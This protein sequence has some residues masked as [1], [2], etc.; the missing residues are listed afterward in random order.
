MFILNAMGCNSGKKFT[1]IDFETANR[2]RSSICSVGISVFE[3]GLEIDSFYSLVKPEPFK[4]EIQ[5]QSVNGVT[6]ADVSNAPSLEDVFPKI[7]G[8]LKTYVIAHNAEFDMD[9]LS[10]WLFERKMAFP[11]FKYLCTK[12]ISAILGEPSNSLDELCSFYGIKICKIHNALCDARACGELFFKLLP[13]LGDE[14]LNDISTEF[15]TRV[16][17]EIEQ[18][19]RI[20]SRHFFDGGPLVEV[21]KV[22]ETKNDLPYQE[23][24]SIDFSKNFVVTGEFLNFK[25]K[26]LE[27]KIKA[28]GG[29]L[30]SMPTAKT[31][32]III[33]GIASDG[34][35]NGNYGRK[36]E[37]ALELPNVI[38]VRESDFL[39]FV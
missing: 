4:I 31:S 9:C 25:R 2:Q 5:C 6:Y 26:E 29:K 37:A 34:W 28:R 7:K 16:Y 12:K 17:K 35:A 14:K 24:D 21:E 22:A 38:F 33:G 8:Y 11:D 1:F 20:I 10:T 18:S 19:E 36:I 3:N 39:K 15:G 23:V 32:Y 30:Q 13:K 27:D